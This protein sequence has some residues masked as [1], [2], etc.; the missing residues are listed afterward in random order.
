MRGSYIA[1]CEKQQ[2]FTV[3]MKEMG[4]GNRVE[5]SGVD[6][7]CSMIF[8]CPFFFLVEIATACFSSFGFFFFGFLCIM[9]EA[10][11]M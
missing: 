3:E 11:M 5:W 1:A 7:F 10:L 6:L 9:I 8:F 2:L 4:K